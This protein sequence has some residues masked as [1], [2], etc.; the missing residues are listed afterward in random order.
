MILRKTWLV[1]K[2]EDSACESISP[3]VHSS[4]R[5]AGGGRIGGYAS[6]RG[7]ERGRTNSASVTDIKIAS[8]FLVGDF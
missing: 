7:S 5:N 2:T 6:N 3:E 8:R 1:H 4:F